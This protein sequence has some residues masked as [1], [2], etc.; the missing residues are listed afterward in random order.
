MGIHGVFMA[1][2]SSSAPPAQPRPLSPPKTQGMAQIPAQIP[3]SPA[4]N[5]HQRHRRSMATLRTVAAL[6]LREMSTR[7]GR[8][9]GGYLWG[10]LEP[11]AA[12]L[13]LSLGFSLVIRTPSLGTSFLL[14]YAT[15]FLPFNLYQTLSGTVAR[16]LAYSRPLLRYPAVT[17]LDAILARFVLNSL[18]GIV[19]TTLL[20]T[21]ILAVID[22][23]TAID[24]PPLVEAIT[25]AMVLGLGVGCINAVLMGLFPLWDVAWSII[26]RPLFLASG[27]IYIY[28]DLPPVAQD[29]LWYNPLLHI[30]GLMRTGFYPTYNADYVSHSYVLLIGLAL[31]ALGLILMRRYHRVILNR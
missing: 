12:I 29:V 8:T 10:I 16:A 17:W 18:T 6:V 4:A 9:P 11:L 1:S 20:I 2:L 23:R 22:S 14:F 31:T 28:E 21:G 26:T 19:I 15:G 30:T 5:P 27:V 24:L 13:F 25:L 3:T 7:Y